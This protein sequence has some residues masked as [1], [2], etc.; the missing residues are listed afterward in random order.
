MEQP[1]T[2]AP[3][4]PAWWVPALRT[5]FRYLP[6]EEQIQRV[7]NTL[8]LIGKEELDPR[9][10]LIAL[11]L[12]GILGA[13][14]SIRLPGAGG[15]VWPP[16]AIEPCWRARIEDE[17]VRAACAW[18]HTGGAKVAQAIVRPSERFLAVP[19]ERHGFRHVTTLWYLRH[20]LDAGAALATAERQDLSYRSYR[21]VSRRVFEETLVRTYEGTL[22]C[23]ELNGVRT[24]AE[25]LAGHRAQGRHEPNLWWLAESAG[26]PVG[27]LLLSE[28]PEWDA[29][30]ICYLGVVPEARGHGFGRH[31]ALHSLRVARSQ[32]VSQLTLAVD[33]RNRPAW[34]LYRDLG[35]VPHEAR[36]A[37]LLFWANS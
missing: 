6:E 22:D 13:M 21:D 37:F 9:G 26:A 17:L 1:F 30:D 34:D 15:L 14:V 27:V 7:A 35:F 18:L 12:S 25:I 23:P 31:L 29:L 32:G 8:D 11:G 3:A 4:P 36:E 20:S 28:M 19:L 33:R 2:I 5:V 24:A 16:Q 10:I